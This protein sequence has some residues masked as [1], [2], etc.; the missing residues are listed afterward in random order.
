METSVV[1]G[2]HGATCNEERVH[3]GNLSLSGFSCSH[4]PLQEA[5][6]SASATGVDETALSNIKTTWSC[7]IN[8]TEP[9]YLSKQIRRDWDAPVTTAAYN[10]LMSTS[11]SPV[12][13]ARLKAVVTPH[14]G[15]WLYAP[16]MTAVG[17]RLSDEAIRVAIRYRLETNI[18]QLHTCLCS[19]IS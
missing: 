5:I 15:D 3:S 19:A 16:P 4:A 7:L 13:L 10:F 14:A 2:S 8:A 11:Q 1:A 12:D 9:S 6:L 17:L 18:C